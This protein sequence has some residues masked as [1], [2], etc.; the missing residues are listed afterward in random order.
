MSLKNL[1][2]LVHRTLTRSTFN[3]RYCNTNKKKVNFV[4][5]CSNS[6]I[7][8]SKPALSQPIGKVEGKL[9][10]SYKC[11]VCKTTNNHFIT[12]IAYDKGV[13]I[14]TCEGCS[15]NHLIADNLNWFT[16]LNGKKNIEDILAEKGESV[17]KIDV[18][19]CLEI[20]E[21]EVVQK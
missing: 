11:K 12:K 18:N 21:K 1:S 17:R 16:D 7:T 6:N 2:T 5:Y 4:R 10:L 19:K 9:F 15:N 13:V 20:L 8:N 3:I 14:V